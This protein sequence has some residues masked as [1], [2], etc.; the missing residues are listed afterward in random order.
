MLRL[1]DEAYHCDKR[2]SFHHCE[3]LRL[4]FEET[5][6]SFNPKHLRWQIWLGTHLHSAELLALLAAFSSL[7]ILHCA[8]NTS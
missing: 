7:T 8:G 5:A 6:Q 3:V 1:M 2:S 4:N